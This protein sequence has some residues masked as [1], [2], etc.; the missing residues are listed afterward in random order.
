MNKRY[1]VTL[2]TLASI[3]VIVGIAALAGSCGPPGPT[4]VNAPPSAQDAPGPTWDYERLAGENGV[5]DA[6]YLDAAL[7]CV[8]VVGDGGFDLECR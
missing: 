1:S 3:L 2:F 4:A 5:L 7:K 6:W 8:V